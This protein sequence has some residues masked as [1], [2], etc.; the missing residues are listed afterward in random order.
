MVLFSLQRITQKY[1]WRSG[2]KSVAYRITWKGQ[3]QK[4]SGEIVFHSGRSLHI[5]NDDYNFYGHRDFAVWHLD[6]G[7][8][9]YR[10]YR[11]FLY[12]PRRGAFVEH[13]SSCGDDFINIRVDR[14]RKALVSTYFREK[15]PTPC[16]NRLGKY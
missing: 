16:I 11:I 4:K 12:S 2:K 10:I 7:M 1:F 15:V 6:D 9:V 14:R 13:Y 3:R 8:G 5:E